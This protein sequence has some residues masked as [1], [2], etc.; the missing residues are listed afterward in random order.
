MN[1]NKTRNVNE[2]QRKIEVK[3]KII[4]LDFIQ[5]I[6]YS[7]LSCNCLSNFKLNKNQY[8]LVKQKE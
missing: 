3:L 4:H 1:T 6:M 7:I 2:I 8:A 5:T